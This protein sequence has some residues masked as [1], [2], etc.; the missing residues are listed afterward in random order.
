MESSSDSSDEE[1]D[2]RRSDVDRLRQADEVRALS[3]FSRPRAPLSRPVPAEE[4]KRGIYHSHVDYV[5]GTHAATAWDRMDQFKQEKFAER[6]GLLWCLPCD[7]S[8]SFKKRSHVE[9]HLKTAAHVQNKLKH[10]NQ[11]TL[12]DSV[13]AGKAIKASG[14]VEGSV[15]PPYVL[16][17][18]H[19]VVRTMIGA[20]IRLGKLDD[21]GVQEIIVHP[22]WLEQSDQLRKLIPDI[23]RVEVKHLKKM[24]KG[25]CAFFPC[26]THPPCRPVS[27]FFDG[28]PRLGEVCAVVIRFVNE[29]LQVVQ[30][31]IGV[32]H[33]DMSPNA[34]KLQLIIQDI[35]GQVA[36]DFRNLLGAGHDSVSV[37]GAAMRGLKP[38][39]PSLCDMI[40]WCHVG[41]R[42]WKQ[43]WESCPLAAKLCSHWLIYFS[44]NNM[45]RAHCFRA[46]SF[47][48]ASS[49]CSDL[50]HDLSG[51]SERDSLVRPRR[52]C[53]G[54]AQRRYARSG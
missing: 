15:V 54:C 28:T 33:T 17:H 9:Q 43:L 32:R 6:G 16:S 7:H 46:S 10:K 13:K 50:W 26:S 30:L 42:T 19:K 27:I 45:V 29:K 20:G 40:C 48:G 25:K 52:C 35:L 53:Q 14:A 51:D 44:H 18:R 41:D 49:L 37:N 12:E 5:P 3:S 34:H 23:L 11:K 38:A 24:L 39:M 1:G 31:V 36:I 47:L 21:P 2:T 4:R 22:Q 8:I